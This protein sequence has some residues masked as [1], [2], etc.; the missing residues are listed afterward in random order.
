M[1]HLMLTLMTSSISQN[2]F[3][4]CPTLKM[5]LF[6]L[7]CLLFFILTFLLI[8]SYFYILLDIFKVTSSC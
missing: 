6:Q 8:S 3:L 2:E 5:G 7:F 1:V 4:H